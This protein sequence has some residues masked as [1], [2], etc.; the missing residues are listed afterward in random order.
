MAI[1]QV[2]QRRLSDD[3]VERLESMIL[4]GTFRAG[5]RLPAERVLAEQFGVSRP[6]LREAIQKLAAKGLLISR[7]GGGNYVANSI[8]ST[9]SDP[10]LHLLENN[11]EAQ[12]DL[13]E[14]RHTLEGACAHYAAQRATALDHQRLT[15]AFEGLQA[16]Y[17]RNVKV[18]QEEGAA[19]ASFHLAI[20]EASHNTVLLH[21]IRGL[22]ELLKHNVVTNIGG[23]Y[24]Q[25]AETREQLLGQ[26]RELYEAIM[27]GRAE[28]AREISHRHI[29]Y[30]QEVLEEAQDEARRLQRAQRR[31]G[32]VE[33]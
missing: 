13:L 11:P 4:E 10:L 19:D 6:S 7:Q 21:T 1:N 14:F 33:G 29:S 5:D 30:I 9:F 15:Q 17:Q 31:Q 2:R 18:S 22:F 23:M 24:A 20:A 3:I 26:H 28:E 32:A 25:R 27:Q 16:C 8:G 12:H